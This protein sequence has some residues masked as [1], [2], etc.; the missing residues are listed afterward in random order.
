MLAGAW[1]S[2]LF[3]FL[4]FQHLHYDGSSQGSSLGLVYDNVGGEAFNVLFFWIED[5][6]LRE[7]L[8]EDG[9]HG[10]PRL[11]A[12]ARTRDTDRTKPTGVLPV[13]PLG[14]RRK[15]GT[16]DHVSFSSV[17]WISA[18]RMSLAK[19]AFSAAAVAWKHAHP[20]CAPTDPA[21]SAH[22]DVV[23]AP[24]GFPCDLSSSSPEAPVLP[25][26]TFRSRRDLE[27]EIA[28]LR[29]EFSARAVIAAQTPRVGRLVGEPEDEDEAD[30]EPDMVPQ[31]VGARRRQNTARSVHSD[32]DLR[33]QQPRGR[34]ASVTR[35][36]S[37]ERSADEEVNA[38]QRGRSPTVLGCGRLVLKRR[39][40]SPEK[41]DDRSGRDGRDTRPRGSHQES[42]AEEHIKGSAKRA[43]FWRKGRCTRSPQVCQACQAAQ[44]GAGDCFGCPVL[45]VEARAQ[46]NQKGHGNNLKLLGPRIARTSILW[47]HVARV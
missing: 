30:W 6:G 20:H 8:D 22:A 5:V 4:E 35:E 9:G 12:A 7:W 10:N 34:W 24:G 43:G 31:V 47:N 25:L 29:A 3:N 21:H 16:V 40:R 38:R 23:R 45:R 36:A 15:L 42:G 27:S 14:V 19:G 1:N 41:R 32:C 17:A 18:K 37:P 46:G 44:V 33:E 11:Y 2:P 28:A 13:Q 39:H 26:P